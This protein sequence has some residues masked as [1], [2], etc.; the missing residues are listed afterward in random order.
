MKGM[1][2]NR[3]AEGGESEW[4][5]EWEAAAGQ[6]GRWRG[7]RDRGENENGERPWREKVGM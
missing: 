3:L 4:R 1:G 6:G 5:G 2:E 7:W